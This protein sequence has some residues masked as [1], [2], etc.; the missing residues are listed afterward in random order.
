MAKTEALPTVHP[1]E[2]DF[3]F[4]L[5][6]TDLNWQGDATDYYGQVAR[7]AADFDHA[8]DELVDPLQPDHQ[9]R[10]AQTSSRDIW[11]GNL[12]IKLSSTR[13]NHD[14]FATPGLGFIGD[15]QTRSLAIE[16][17]T[18][19]TLH[20]VTFTH[21]LDDQPKI[22]WNASHIS[23]VATARREKKKDIVPIFGGIV[24]GSLEPELE[25]I[26]TGKRIS[27]LDY[28]RYESDDDV[29]RRF[30]LGV[31]VLKLVKRHAEQ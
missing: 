7:A 16:T 13:E 27:A 2:V 29:A 31:E 30:G 1:Q 28:T 4:V 5:H 3:D 8:F 23:V 15:K 20:V 9:R 21:T 24:D 12:A 10:V 22:E 25:V 19:D 11:M 17:T 6:T 26:E 18:A 14:N